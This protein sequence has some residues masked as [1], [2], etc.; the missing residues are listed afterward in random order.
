M[1]FTMHTLINAYTSIFYVF[2]TVYIHLVGYY[3]W[4][5]FICMSTTIQE[6]GTNPTDGY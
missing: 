2:L 3:S 4:S 5:T 1:H 6:T